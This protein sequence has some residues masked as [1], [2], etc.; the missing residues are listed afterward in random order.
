MKDSQNNNTNNNYKGDIEH[1]LR[2]IKN[3]IKDL[4]NEI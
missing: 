2:Q 1:E 3:D 4:K